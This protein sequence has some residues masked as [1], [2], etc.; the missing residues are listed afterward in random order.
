MVLDFSIQV[1]SEA[2]QDVDSFKEWFVDIK[3]IEFK[4]EHPEGGIA[5]YMV[6]DTPFPVQDRDLLMVMREIDV[7]DSLIRISTSA[8]PD[9]VEVDDDYV[10]MPYSQGEWILESI[11]EDRTRVVQVNLSDPGGSIP[12]WVINMM[13]TSNPYNTFSNLRDYLAENN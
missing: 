13:L 4:G 9:F 10:R 2:I 12:K 3:Q 5:V 1:V 7:N 8:D 6:I 11:D